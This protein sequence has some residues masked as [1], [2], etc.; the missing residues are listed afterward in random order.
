[1]GVLVRKKSMVRRTNGGPCIATEK[2]LF[3]SCNKDQNIKVIT[4]PW[5]SAV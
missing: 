4:K 1:M 2:K 5:H 3:T